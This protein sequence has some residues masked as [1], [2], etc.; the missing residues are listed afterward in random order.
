MKE[1][2]AEIGSTLIIILFGISMVLVMHEIL[3]YI[4]FNL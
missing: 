4:S 2:L 3:T 1:F